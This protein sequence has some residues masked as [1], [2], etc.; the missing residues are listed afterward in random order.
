MALR[1]LH[2]QEAASQFRF[3]IAMASESEDIS[4]VEV[5]SG[6]GP[7]VGDAETSAVSAEE[8]H[9]RVDD[10]QAGTPGV[11]VRVQPHLLQVRDTGALDEPAR[12][13]PQPA[14]NC[15]ELQEPQRRVGTVQ[16][17]CLVRA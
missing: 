2:V 11:R 10:C 7:K 4:D 6:P 1:F 5:E 14:P 9:R 15:T 3:G 17:R 8:G 13:L 16:C 12:T